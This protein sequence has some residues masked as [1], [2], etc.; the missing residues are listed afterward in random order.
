MSQDDKSSVEDSM[1]DESWIKKAWGDS[2]EEFIK[3]AG[4]MVR[5]RVQ[6][7][8]DIAELSPGMDVLD[9]GCGRGEVVF[10][11]AGLGCRATGV[12]YSTDVISIAKQ[13][14]ENFHTESGGEAVF[15]LGDVNTI[16]LEPESFD[17]IFL[18]DVVEHL[19]DWQLVPLYQTIHRLLKKDGRFIIHTLPNRW[20]Y[21]TYGLIRLFMPWLEKNPRSEYEKKI[22]I[23]EQSCISVR[24][25]L[26]EC[27]FHCR[28]RIEE[29]FLAQAQWYKNN[30]FGD[31]RDRLYRILRNPLIR[32]VVRL[33][34]LTP[35]RLFVLNDIYSVA[36]K[37]PE[38]LARSGFRK[39]FFESMLS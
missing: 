2:T 33:I 15:L 10:Y 32:A 30:T 11:C 4:R 36:A 31:R 29:G 5:P 13:A 7:A 22:H 16:D 35:L 28:V 37:S 23:N 3:H 21:K 34:A 14:R 24:K 25:L 27:H 6:R 18:L 26:E 12:D 1:Y 20:I 39:G 9:I 38:A 19:H 17:R 8:M